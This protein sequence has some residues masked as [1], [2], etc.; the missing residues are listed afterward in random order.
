MR[1]R[2]TVARRDHAEKE[3]A[4]YDYYPDRRHLSEEF[5]KLWTAQ[6]HYAPDILT[7][8]LR[9]EIGLIIFHQRPLKT[10]EVGL[11]LFTDQRRIPSARP[12]NQ[13][14]ILLETVNAL[15]IAALGEPKRSLTHDERDKILFALD[16]KK[17]AK[18]ALKSPSNGPSI[19]L[20]SLGR[21]IKLRP[22]Q[23]FTLETANRDAIACDPVRASLSHPN[24]MGGVWT[25]LDWVAQMKIVRRIRNV[26]SE[27]CFEVFVHWLIKTYN[28]SEANAFETARSPLP[29]GYGRLGLSA[30]MRILVALEADVIPYSA[31]V[32][33]CGWH[34]SDNRTGEVL[35]ELPDYC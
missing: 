2:L 33:A 23:S 6:S 25:T 7:D 16:N 24:R 17:P 20:K 22:G 4:G 19:T 14:R 27:N 35:K 3:E 10:P 21:E 31:A 30:T 34:H 8:E 12:L 1:T 26:Q 29:E 32:A 9:D 11:C 13:R 28:L 15:R 5:D 18:K